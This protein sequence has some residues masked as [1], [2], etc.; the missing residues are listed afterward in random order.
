M[1][2]AC[3]GKRPNVRRIRSMV[4]EDRLRTNKPVVYDSRAILSNRAQGKMLQNTR[5]RS[6]VL[7]QTDGGAWDVGRGKTQHETRPTPPAAD[8]RLWALS[9]RVFAAEA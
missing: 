3:S 6:D 2:K 4:I 1:L 7:K 8:L 9:R 5:A